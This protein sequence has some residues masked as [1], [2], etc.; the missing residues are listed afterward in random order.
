[1]LGYGSNHNGFHRFNGCSN[2]FNVVDIF[3]RINDGI[4]YTTN[5][6]SN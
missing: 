4:V 5:I 1:M 2:Q 3:N 6:R